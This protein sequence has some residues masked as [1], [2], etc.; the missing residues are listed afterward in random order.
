MENLK[1][2]LQ[3]APTD[4]QAPVHYGYGVSR[5]IDAKS[6]VWTFYVSIVRRGIVVKRQFSETRNGGHDGAMARATGYRDQVLGELPPYSKREYQAIVRT[7]NTSGITGVRRYRKAGHLVWEACAQFPSG[8]SKSRA[9]SINK[10][11]DEEA[12][13]LAVQARAAMLQQIDGYY[14]TT[15]EAKLVS[16]EARPSLLAP[17][18]G[19][20]LV[21]PA[22]PREYRKNL[23][24]KPFSGC[25]G[26]TWERGVNRDKAGKI[27]VERHYWVA[28][29]TVR[30]VCKVRYF[31]IESGHE[32]E[33]F[34]LAVAQREAWEAEFGR[35]KI[36]AYR[37]LQHPTH[38]RRKFAP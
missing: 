28:R 21:V 16:E 7:S 17:P 35:P 12:K 27:S 5:K 8:K 30:G 20:Q 22:K 38:N 3:H 14:H 18:S 6:G 2:V 25:R 24:C 9:F 29:Y 10:Y 37:T 13:Q 23:K 15:E 33:A 32:E 26:V 31:R 36:G 34:R 4:G 11:G 19:V 1:T